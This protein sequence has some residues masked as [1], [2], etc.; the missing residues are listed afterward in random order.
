MEA[1]S[2][3]PEQEVEPEPEPVVAAAST[4]QGQGLCAIVSFDYEASWWFPTEEAPVTNA[5]F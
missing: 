2:V 3:E 5:G 1:L 4:Y